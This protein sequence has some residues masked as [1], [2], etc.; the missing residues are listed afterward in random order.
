MYLVETAR[1]EHPNSNPRSLHQIANR[2]ALNRKLE[3][4]AGT[5][6]TY[7]KRTPFCLQRATIIPALCP[8]L[9]VE[10]L[11]SKNGARART[12]FINNIVIENAGDKFLGEE[13]SPTVIV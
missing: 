10:I 12:V 13:I 9:V 4:A 6:M 2:P 1:A 7:A 8:P 5:P 11:V 3:I